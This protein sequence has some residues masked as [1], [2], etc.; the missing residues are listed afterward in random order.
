MRRR[1]RP[2]S[3]GS[4][5]PSTVECAGLWMLPE[6]R[7]TTRGAWCWLLLL[8][9]LRRIPRR[10]LLL[11]TYAEGLRRLYLQMHAEIISQGSIE[12]GGRTLPRYVMLVSGKG[13]FLDIV[14]GESLR[15]I[16][17]WAGATVARGLRHLQTAMEHS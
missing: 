12:R 8:A 9:H 5:S 15:R 13:G 7:R 3:P 1:C 2:S 4:T 11:V 10:D 14:V 6:V 16:R 17:A